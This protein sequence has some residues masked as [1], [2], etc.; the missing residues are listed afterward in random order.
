MKTAVHQY[1]DKLLEFAYGELPTHEASAVEAHVRGCARCTQA[2]DEIRSVRATMSQL[3]AESAPDAGLES[4]LA[5][6]ESAAKR[7]A[8]AGKPV[9]FWKKYLTPLVLVATM[10]TVGV[11]ATQA[12]KEV[13]LSPAAAASDKTAS[14]YSRRDERKIAKEEGKKEEAP[15]PVAAVP[16]PAPLQ[17]KQGDL[18]NA[19]VE[20]KQLAEVNTPGAGPRGGEAN[21]FDSIGTLGKRGTGGLGTGDTN[22]GGMQSITRREVAGTKGG[23]RMNN[24][25]FAPMKAKLQTKE[26]PSKMPAP[27]PPAAT[28]PADKNVADGLY[29]LSGGST[30]NNWSNSGAAVRAQET[31]EKDALNKRDEEEARK[32]PEPIVAKNDPTPDVTTVPKEAP[33][34]EAKPSPRPESK[35]ATKSMSLGG[36]YAEGSLSSAEDEAAPTLDRVGAD[37]DAKL[38]ERQRGATVASLLEQAK[39][40]AQKGD[41]QA[42][43]SFAAQ[44]IG[45]GGLPN[46]ARLEALTHLCNGYEALG[47]FDAADGWCDALL[48]EFPSSSSAQIIT[49]RRGASQQYRAAPAASKKKSTSVPAASESAQ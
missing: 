47:Q 24:D 40:A 30:S 31:R 3:P 15:A 27:P 6:A 38:A 46:G 44:A 26:E 29:G 28:P 21:E 5:F 18:G 48:R 11:V 20:Q 34:T 16:T 4:L 35:K 22:R 23:G 43:V 39:A 12:N 37:S 10:V 42:E 41:R 33:K 45:Q 2:L 49:Q 9:P 32:A 14:D 1:E 17:A 7:N 36:G 25:D 19:L 8:E 13:D